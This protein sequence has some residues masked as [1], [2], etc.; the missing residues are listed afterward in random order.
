LK[1]DAVMQDKHCA[2]LGGEPTK[3]PFN[4]IQRVH[5]VL[6]GADRCIDLDDLDLDAASPPAADGPVAASDEDPV[7]PAVERA[8]VA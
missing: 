2:M 4:L 5:A 1:T 8:R 7:E 3:G 6:V